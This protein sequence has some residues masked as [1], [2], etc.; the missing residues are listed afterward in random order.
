MKR[1]FDIGVVVVALLAVPLCA[2][3]NGQRG[4]VRRQPVDHSQYGQMGAEPGHPGQYGHTGGQYGYTGGQY[5]AKYQPGAMYGGQ[6]GAYQGQFG[7]IRQPI[8]PRFRL[9][10]V[11]QLRQPVHPR[12]S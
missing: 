1:C 11:W 7:R 9:R 6:M 2:G 12:M 4:T 8:R 3:S 5:G 10:A